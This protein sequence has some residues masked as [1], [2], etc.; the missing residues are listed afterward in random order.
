M[1][2]CCSSPVDDGE[3]EWAGMG[4]AEKTVFPLHSSPMGLQVIC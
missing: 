3:K 1:G 4:L 2:M